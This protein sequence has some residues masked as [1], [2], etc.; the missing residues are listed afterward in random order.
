[1]A[2]QNQKSKTIALMGVLSALV[3]IMAFT[4]I[5]Y[6]RVGVIS[7]SFLMIPVA[8]GAVARGPMGG[9]ILGTV[10]GITSF[11]QCFGMDAFGTFLAQK[12][13]FFTFI[14]CVVARALAGAIA[15][16]VYNAIAKASKKITLSA[17]ICGLTAALSNTVLFV[18][19]LI[20]LFGKMNIS[21]ATSGA[22]PADAS[23]ITFI[24]AFITVNAVWEAV[25][26]VIFTGA[27]ALALYKAKL[28][29]LP[30]KA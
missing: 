12:N 15:G 20:L 26:A 24:T 10:F 25:A 23:I 22:L 2:K 7:I 19:A 13:V 30:S 3:I 1:M 4:P 9:A 27:I 5:G 18:G 21:E 28:I 6:L 14:M 11:A 29:T 17:S 16:V 8:I